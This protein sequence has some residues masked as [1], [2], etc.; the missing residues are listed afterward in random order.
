[1][2]HCLLKLKVVEIADCLFDFSEDKCRI[3][4]DRNFFSMLFSE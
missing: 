1:M 4:L 2:L 3:M